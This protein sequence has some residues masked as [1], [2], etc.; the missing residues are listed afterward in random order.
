M[1]S[2]ILSKWLLKPVTNEISR[3][4]AHTSNQQLKPQQ[5]TTGVVESTD[6]EMDGRC[7]GLR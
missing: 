3:C 7:L 2:I 6:G 5:L 4:T 1:Q